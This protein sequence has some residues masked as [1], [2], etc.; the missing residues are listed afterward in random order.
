[1]ADGRG[2]GRA[3]LGEGA[4]SLR[5]WMWL[6]ILVTIGLAAVAALA[7][8]KVLPPALL[9]PTTLLTFASAL[10]ALWCGARG[11]RRAIADRE[12]A[13]G[14][15]MVIALATQLGRQDDGALERLAA[16]AGPAGEAARLI[17]QGR[18]SP[19]PLDQVRAPS[20]RPSIER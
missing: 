17:L 4:E 5:R 6:L 7:L 1:M 3:S 2:A 16:G 14:Q 15:A 8:R 20:A 18:R 13:S 9:V 11:H 12:R 19:H 10:S